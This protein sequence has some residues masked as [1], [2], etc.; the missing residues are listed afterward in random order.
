V[1]SLASSAGGLLGAAEGEVSWLISLS[2]SLDRSRGAFGA[3]L[4]AGG[5]AE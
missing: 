5:A 4:G 3:C 1:L 2:A